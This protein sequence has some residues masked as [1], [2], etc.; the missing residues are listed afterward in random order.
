VAGLFFRAV[1][2]APATKRRDLGN[3]AAKSHFH[4]PKLSS[5]R[6]HALFTYPFFLS[7]PFIFPLVEIPF[8][9]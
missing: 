3:D 7:F 9:I 8:S 4:P 6:Y 5:V 1:R 2:G